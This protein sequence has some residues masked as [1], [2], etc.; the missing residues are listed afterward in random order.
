MQATWSRTMA[1][2]TSLG[3]DAVLPTAHTHGAFLHI[4]CHCYMQLGDCIAIVWEGVDVL[5]EC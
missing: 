4:S 1:P 3:P 2:I 5:L